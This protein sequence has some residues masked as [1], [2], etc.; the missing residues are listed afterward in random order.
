MN[1]EELGWFR[2]VRERKAERRALFLP[3]CPTERSFNLIFER[4]ERRS[5]RGEISGYR[6]DMIPKVSS[7]I[8][9]VPESSRGQGI[10]FLFR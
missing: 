3:S 4:D 10:P 2:P 6:R 1:L 7:S 9:G 8:L 5:F